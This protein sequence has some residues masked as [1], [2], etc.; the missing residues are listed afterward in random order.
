MNLNGDRFEMGN[1]KYL[2][3]KRR[4]SLL[5]KRAMATNLDGFKKGLQSVMFS[6]ATSCDAYVF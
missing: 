6:K 1:G 4:N 2:A 3:R 5:Y